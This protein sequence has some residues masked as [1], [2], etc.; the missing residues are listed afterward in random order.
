[1]DKHLGLEYPIG[2][3]RRKFLE[4]NC[5]KVEDYGYMKRFQPDEI[6]HRK[7]LLAEISIKIAELEE[8]KKKA[9][10]E[11]KALLKSPGEE[12]AELLQD[13]KNGAS[14]VKELCYKFVYHDEDMAVYYNADGEMVSSR[15]LFPEEK[16]TTIFQIHR[17]GTND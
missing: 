8:A 6:D 9:M 14:F 13:L 17:T 16:Q 15:P 11:F 1:M 5:D 3:A 10:D 12:K 7:T 4:A 2:D